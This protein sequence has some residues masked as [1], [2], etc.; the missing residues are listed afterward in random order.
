M[1]AEKI[2]PV[3]PESLESEPDDAS[4]PVQSKTIVLANWTLKLSISQA[5]SLLGFSL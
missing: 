5:G 3:R 4:H 1:N 2:N